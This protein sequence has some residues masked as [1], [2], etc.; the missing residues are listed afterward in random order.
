MK[1]RL[2]ALTLGLLYVPISSAE[3]YITV[4]ALLVN[5]ACTVTDD[6]GAKELFIDFQNVD[7]NAVVKTP[8]RNFDVLIKD[9]NLNKMMNL[10]LSPKDNGYFSYNGVDVLATTTDQLGIEFSDI[11]SGKRKINVQRYERIT[12]ILSSSNSGKISLSTQ[13]VANK[14]GTELKMGP[15]TANV[16]LLVDYN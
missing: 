7:V 12:P 2:I 11:T 13:L 15:F 6:K 3:I 16:S 9:C 10:Y 5:P 4:N 8:P 1:K 14:P